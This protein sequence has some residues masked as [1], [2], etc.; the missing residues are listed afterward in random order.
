MEQ[1]T[2]EVSPVPGNLFKP[3]IE[4]MHQTIAIGQA[5]HQVPA[6]ILAKELL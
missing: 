5:D 6:T 3:L 2:M 1:N 4:T